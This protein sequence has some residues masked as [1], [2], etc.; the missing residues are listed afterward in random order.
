MKNKIIKADEFFSRPPRKIEWTIRN[1]VEQGTFVVLGGE[2]KT[3]KTWA[4]LEIALSVASGSD[5]FNHDEFTTFGQ[6][7]PVFMFLLEDNED[8]VQARMTALAAAKGMSV[9]H[10]TTLPLFI[11]C[12]EPLDIIDQANEIIRIVKELGV[13]DEVTPGLL[14]ER[15]GLIIIDPLR[16]AHS[17]DENDST[18]M[19]KV[20]S[21]CLRIRNATGYSLMINHHF[22]KMKKADED[23]PGNAMRGTSS[24]YGAV[25]GIIGMRKIES[26]ERNTWNNNVICQVKAGPQ[27]EPFGLTL[28]VKDGKESGRAV[29]ADWEVE[30]IFG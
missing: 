18:S 7:R 16:N 9:Q 4:G 22:K 11:L 14:R 26:M 21:E 30:G 13:H 23:S 10:L 3:S 8:N 1:L 28:R 25:D 24:L 19:K 5:A 2:P 6:Q 12:R 29:Y 17:E 27:A 20:L 15:R